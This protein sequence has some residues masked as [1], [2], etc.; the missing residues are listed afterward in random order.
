M[1]RFGLILVT[2]V[3]LATPAW[4]QDE[5]ARAQQQRL[6]D[7][8][9]ALPPAQRDWVR[10]VFGLITIAE[11]EYFLAAPEYRRDAFV[12]E[13]WKVRD[14]DPRTPGNELRD[15]FEELRQSQGPAFTAADPRYRLFLFNGPPTG[16][17]LPDGR[18]VTI[19]FGR[20]RELEIWF[21][22]GSPR[23]AQRFI[24]VFQRRSPNSGYEAWL[25]GAPLRPI[26]RSGLPTQDVRVLCADELLGFAQREISRIGNYDQVLESALAAPQPPQ[27]WLADLELDGVEIP[28][29]ARTFEVQAEIRFPSRRQ[30]RTGLQVLVPVS[31]DVAPG[32][33][34][35]D[36]W[37]HHFVLV[38][39]ILRDGKLF[40]EFRYRFEG[41]TAVEARA[42]PLGFTRFLRPGAVQLRL[43]IEDVFGE[44]YSLIQADLDVPS[45]EGRETA[46]GAQLVTAPR[47]EGPSLQLMSPSR[48][49]IAGKVRFEARA[50]GDIDRVAFLLDGRQVLAKRRPPYSAEL[51]LGEAP[52]PHTVR[53]VGYFEGNEVATDQLWLN[54]GQQRFAVRL[55]EPR[56]RGL[57]PSGVVARAA[58]QTP[59][60]QEIERLEFYLDGELV[61]TRTE[62]PFAAAMDLGSGSDRVVSVVGLL[63][64][65]TR[66]EDAVVVGSA[67][68]DEQVEVTAV[69]LF[70]DVRDPDGQPVDDLD[71][72]EL[73]VVETADDRSITAVDVAVQSLRDAPL[74]VALVLDTSA[75]MNEA[76]SVVRSG[77]S[78]LVEGL[79]ASDSR[80]GVLTFS[81]RVDVRQPLGSSADD[82]ERTLAGVAASGRTALFDALAE[83]SRFLRGGSSPQ[84]VVVVTDGGDDVSQ[85]DFD[86]TLAALEASPAVYVILGVEGDAPL[87]DEQRRRLETLAAV[88]GGSAQFGVASD[89]LPEAL[90]EG[91]REI[92]KGWW[93][94]YTSPFPGEQEA[95]D[96]AVGIDRDGHVATVR[97]RVR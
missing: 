32:R 89:R 81:D 52:V 80:V 94:S 75:S 3:L 82:L 64:D 54:Q 13:F 70:L 79:L 66:S 6:A 55:V 10:S 15:R 27:E 60:G 45:P 41:P 63:A 87:P 39:E 97:P 8:V 23:V 4:S 96:T 73:R 47:T 33:Q 91:V 2:F 58:V 53:V 19:C 24:A 29:G 30:S 28:E 76:L 34:F 25:P 57:Y 20:S 5:A 26:Q 83:G 65:G 42:V 85:L 7:G 62:E 61:A 38:G 35:D 67:T 74:D 18:A 46:R 31:R 50:G 9:N 16:W 22:S 21:Y 17:S 71:A 12:P 36:G 77:E 90:L 92:R 40:E 37:A 68:F 88:S 11:L 95:R 69:E 49:S 43:R 14:P 1:P 56:P 51:D 78:G 48:G 86:Q 59:A 72:E 44:Q 93:L 84:L